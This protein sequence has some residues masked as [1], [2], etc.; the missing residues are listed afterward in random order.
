MNITKILGL[1]SA[2]TSGVTNAPCRLSEGEDSLHLQPGGARVGH[3]AAHVDM[4]ARGGTQILT[5]RWNKCLDVKDG[6][7]ANA[8][9]VQLWDCI[10]NNANQQWQVSGNTIKSAGGKCLDLV[11][12]WAYPGANIQL[13]DCDN[14][15]PNQFFEI[16]GNS[17]RKK[18][19]NYCLDVRDG[20]YDNGGGLQLWGC[21]WNQNGNQVLKFGQTTQATQQSAS[22]F[23][24]YAMI[25]ID[26]FVARNPEC[27]PWRDAFVLAGSQFNLPATLIGAIAE[28]EATCQERPANGFGMFQFMSWDAWNLVNPGKDYQN[29]WDA[30]WGAARYIRILLDQNNQNLDAALRAY[31]GPISQGGLPSYQSDIRGW[32]SGQ[33]HW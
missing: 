29:A 16:A 17:I 24:G 30:S 33:K 15:N 23:S 19:T 31:N 27:K 2:A 6:K 14:K 22:S 25:S 3:A 20:R 32:C 4:F 13:W 21:D 28:Q 1:A 10:P 9:G 7:Q 12:G 26:A 8:N 11:N 18:N 5:T